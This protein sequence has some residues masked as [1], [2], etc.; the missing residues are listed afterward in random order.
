M[1]DK[2]SVG[3][4]PIRILNKLSDAIFDKQNYFSG[5]YDRFSQVIL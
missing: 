1:S 2:I 3:L 5:K 4:L